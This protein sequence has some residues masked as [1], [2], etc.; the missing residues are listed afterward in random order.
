MKP[1]NCRSRKVRRQ[2]RAVR[3][4]PH[5]SSPTALYLPVHQAQAA[6]AVRAKWNPQPVKVL[7]LNPLPPV[8]AAVHR[9]AAHN[10]RVLY[11][12]KAPYSRRARRSPKAPHSRRAR[13]SPKAPHSRRVRLN[14]KAPLNR[15]VRHSPRVRHSRK[16]LS[17]RRHL[18]VL[19]NSRA[20]RHR[21]AQQVNP[22]S[23]AAAVL[24]SRSL[25][26][27]SAESSFINSFSVWT[28][29]W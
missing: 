20:H 27:I 19:P 2:T 16:A 14:H 25:P 28:V 21:A 23:R 11:S 6:Q 15:K 29:K 18:H 22:A 4:R 7:P 13:R 26:Q 5:L 3:T 9:R 10:R 1:P 24:I 8:Q 12:P 17:V